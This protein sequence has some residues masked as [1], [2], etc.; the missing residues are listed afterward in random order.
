[1]K[2]RTAPRTSEVT[3]EMI[4]THGRENIKWTLGKVWNEEKYQK[5]ERE[6]ELDQFLRRRERY[7]RMVAAG[8]TKKTVLKVLRRLYG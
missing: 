2:T 7:W 3:T 5:I 8:G 6:V 1:M 4:K